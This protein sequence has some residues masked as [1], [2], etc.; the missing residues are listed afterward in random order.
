MMTV[1]AFA[2]FI[3]AVIVFEMSKHL[4][5]NARQVNNRSNQVQPGVSTDSKPI[6]RHADF[7]LHSSDERLEP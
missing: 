4:F 1:W 3:L 5:R 6:E 7:A 2:G